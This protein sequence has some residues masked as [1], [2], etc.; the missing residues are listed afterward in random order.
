[1]L[2]PNILIFSFSHI[3]NWIDIKNLIDRLGY[4]KKSYYLGIRGKT[5]R[6]INFSKCDL[7][8][9]CRNN[10]IRLYQQIRR[11]YEQLI[12]YIT[13]QVY[14]SNKTGEYLISAELKIKY[15]Y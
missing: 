2:D 12:D 10:L 1:M 5:C 4:F 3:K 7:W 14:F 11:I 15:K 9:Y 6:E 8:E 13:T